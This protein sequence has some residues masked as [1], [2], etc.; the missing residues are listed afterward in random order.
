MKNLEKYKNDLEKL[1]S[2]G[3]KLLLS[4]KYECYPSEFEKQVKPKLKDKYESYIKK[5]KPFKQEYQQW[6][7]EALVLIR[8]LLPDRVNDFVKLYEKPKTRKAIEYGNYV[9][10]DYLQN[11]TVTSG[12]GEKKVGPEGAISQFEQQLFIV[13]SVEKRFESTLFDIRQLTQADLFDS[14]LD[15]SKELNKKGFMRGAGAIA[16]VVLEKHLYQVCINHKV[17]ILKKNPSI[18]DFN[19][20]L[21][22]SEVYETPPWRK[23]QHLGDIRNLCD[24]NKSNEPKREDVDELINGVD[25]I[26]KTIY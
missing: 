16:G 20:K 12:F 9:I 10:E 1:I 22:N 25:G 24:H 15:A 7:S 18:A 21:K 2:Y 19:D 4:M 3:E 17:K 23:I 13:K 11:L 6:Y 26:I 14:E 8:Q 5:I